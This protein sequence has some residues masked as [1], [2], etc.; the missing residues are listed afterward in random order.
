MKTLEEI[1]EKLPEEIRMPIYEAFRV[2]KDDIIHKEIIDT[3]EEIKKVWKAINE[4]AEA[5]KKT[6]QRVNELAEAQKKTEQRV[7]E[8]AEAQ[9]KTE[10]RVNEL[11]EAQ[12]KTEQR[13]NELAEEV[14]K[15]SIE[16]KKLAEA[17]FKLVEE[18]RKTR[19]ELGGLSHAFGYVL[20]DRAIKSLPKI[21]KEDYGIEVIGKLKRDY[22][23]INGEY[24]EVNIF[25][26]AK[27]GEKEYM[28]IGEAKS[29]LSKKIID[30]FIKK[31]NKIS[32]ESIKVI[33]SYLFTPEIK[34][35]AE[36]REIITV[37]SYEL[38]L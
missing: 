11:A 23:V 4:L 2:F 14:K 36:E 20:E 10:Q 28:I 9:K 18:H 29:R 8:L 1:I 37:P 5:Q 30:K 16:V 6:E 25:G 22:L 31:C 3:K 27:K 24:I 35:Y 12:K 15:L 32:K 7:N 21:L 33:I 34:K 19:E 17:H 13:V 26:R 38:E